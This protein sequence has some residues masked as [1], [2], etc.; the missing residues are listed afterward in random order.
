[1]FK[2]IIFIVVILSFLGGCSA[3]D[4]SFIT[5]VVNGTAEELGTK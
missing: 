4:R 2:K 1:M 3:Q 5:D